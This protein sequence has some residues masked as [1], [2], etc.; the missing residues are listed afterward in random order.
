MNIPS[1]NTWPNIH[2]TKDQLFTLDFTFH[3]VVITAGIHAIQGKISAC[4]KTPNVVVLS[5]TTIKNLSFDELKTI[6]NAT[7]LS[8]MQDD[9]I[10]PNQF[11]LEYV[12]FRSSNATE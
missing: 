5:E 6:G 7:N 11:R 9:S 10:G 3:T 2:P 1:F 8:I 12:S 4:K